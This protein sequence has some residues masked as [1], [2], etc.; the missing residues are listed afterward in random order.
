MSQYQYFNP[1]PAKTRVGDCT[2]RAICRATGKCWDG[3]FLS[4]SAFA[5]AAKDLPSANAVWGRYLRELGYRRHLI[6]DDREGY[7]VEDFCQDHPEGT[8]ILA[9]DGHV[10]CVQEGFYYDTWDSGKE[11]PVY[12]W[13]KG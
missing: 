7:T 2:V 10:V 8:Y 13:E 9:M 5:F 4:L 6:D 11:I 12:Y 1:N 3:V